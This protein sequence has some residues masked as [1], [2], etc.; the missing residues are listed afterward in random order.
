MY[1][2]CFTDV[3]EAQLAGAAFYGLELLN[4]V[5]TAIA[6]PLLPYCGVLYSIFCFWLQLLTDAAF[7]ADRTYQISS[8]VS[9]GLWGMSLK[10]Y[11]MYT[12]QQL[13]RQ[14]LINTDQKM[15]CIPC[16]EHKHRSWI[17]S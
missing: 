3:I 7:P 13:K 14:A 11:V 15:R 6:V 1:L 2:V 16:F 5:P 9:S 17:F 4:V 10:L 12:Y 8:T